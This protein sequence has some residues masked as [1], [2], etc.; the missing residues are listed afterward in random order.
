MNVCGDYLSLQ[1]PGLGEGRPSLLLGDKVIASLTGYFYFL[2]CVFVFIFVYVSYPRWYLA[3]LIPFFPIF[4]SFE[5]LY[6]VSAQQHSCTFEWSKF[7]ILSFERPSTLSS[8]GK[9]SQL[10]TKQWIMQH[11]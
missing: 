3:L 10:R 2:V 9:F 6:Y 11:K 5:L 7:N 8:P 4:F 1:I